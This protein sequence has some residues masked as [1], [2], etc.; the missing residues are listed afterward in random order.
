MSPEQP[1]RIL[2]TV[3]KLRQLKAN[4]DATIPP[5]ELDEAGWKYAPLA[6]SQRLISRWS[7]GFD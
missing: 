1:F 7:D 3:E 4:L 5:D 6:D 2:V